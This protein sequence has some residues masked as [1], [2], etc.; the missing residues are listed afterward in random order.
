MRKFKIN[1]P[2]RGTANGTTRVPLQNWTKDEVEDYLK[3]YATA[4]RTRAA[5]QK[6]L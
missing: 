4:F 1:L 5:R 2:I 6:Q 3:R